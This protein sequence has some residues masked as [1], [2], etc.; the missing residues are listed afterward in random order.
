LK[1]L[2]DL[3]PKD[4]GAHL[5]MAERRERAGD[6]AGQ[7][8][9]LV[10][11]AGGKAY[12]EDPS[13]ARRAA[14]GVAALKARALAPADALSAGDVQKLQA[15]VARV[16]D[17]AY[18]ERRKQSPSLAGNL[19]L[20]VRVSPKGPVQAVELIEDGVGD[21]LLLACALLTLH[22]ARVAESKGGTFSFTFD[23]RPREARKSKRK[24]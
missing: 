6:L 13:A 22:E 5:Q 2:L 19:Q 4:A 9:E 12:P 24:R 17:R 8:D 23:L 16:I 20:R 7:I 18:E 15:A 1:A 3:D 10:Q 14:A 21:S 11:A